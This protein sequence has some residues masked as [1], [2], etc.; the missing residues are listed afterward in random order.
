VRPHP[1]TVTTPDARWPAE[2]KALVVLLSVSSFSSAMGA[3]VPMSPAAPVRLNMVLAVLGALLAIG[4]TVR[5]HRAW[6]YAGVTAMIV[7]LGLLTASTATPAGTA[8]LGMSFT[9]AAAFSAFFLPRVVARCYGV[10]AVLAFGAGLLSNP[11]YGAAHVWFLTSLTAVVAVEA[12]AALV[13]R[14]DHAAVTDP[15]TGLLNRN[16]LQREAHAALAAAGR[17]GSPLSVAVVDLDGFKAVNDQ[18]GHDAGDRVLAELAASWRKEVRAGDIVARLGG[19]EFVLVLPDTSRADAEDL[20]TRLAAVSATPWSSGVVTSRP[21]NDLRDLL[22]GADR[23]LYA[24]KAR[25]PRQVVLPEQRVPDV[26][27][28]RTPT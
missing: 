18:H 19:D 1:L 3:A 12:V 10:A 26:Q 24:A 21:G 2:R 16:G 9:W 25:R 13:S 20:L 5:P 17:S 6:S 22:V 23:E 8:A 14:L 27:T 4:A 15:L 11:F 28:V 7:G